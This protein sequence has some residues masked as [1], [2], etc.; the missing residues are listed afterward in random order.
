VASDLTAKARLLSA[1]AGAGLGLLV[2]SSVAW[3]LLTTG[4]TLAGAIIAL[5]GV[6]LGGATGWWLGPI[7]RVPS[8]EDVGV[9]Q[10]DGPAIRRRGT[11]A[12]DWFGFWVYGGLLILGGLVA[13]VVVL[14]QS[15]RG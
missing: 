11:V 9:K 3:W 8:E 14:A 1:L 7:S 10:E 4:N 6:A 12:R 15:G 5:L 2:A 13:L